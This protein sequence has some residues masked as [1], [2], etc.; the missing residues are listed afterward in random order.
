MINK[1]FGDNMRIAITGASGQLGK[2]VIEQLA[3]QIDPKDIVALVRKPEKETEL[4]S[5]GVEVRPFDYN[6]LPDQLAKQLHD[7]DKILLI[8]S[9]EV[10]KRTQ[11]HK[12]VIE[13]VKLT[14]IQLIAYTSILNADT[15]PLALAKEHV[16]TEEF[17]KT[18]PISVILLRNGWYSENYAIGLK[19]SV[20]LGKIFGATHHGKISSASRLNYATAAVTILLQ[21]SHESKT[22]ELAG[23]TSYTLDDV[24]G[25]VSEYS[26]KEVVYE[27]LP[28]D[29]YTKLLVEVGLPE[30]FAEILADSDENVSKNGLYS[31][32]KDLHQLIK[33]DT[34][35]M[36][37]T[38]K[39]FLA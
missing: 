1:K 33:R 36:K 13:A 7:I 5:Q 6:D 2:Q 26:D 37:E 27:D 12:N 34:T 22:Y 24:A 23:D 16:E 31:E 17:L 4:K 35:A 18:L 20:E 19:Q 21:S 30:A 32:S 25:W 39:Q 14:N 10:G 38:V 15:S 9:S 29:E 3:K 11:Q 8:S 28:Q